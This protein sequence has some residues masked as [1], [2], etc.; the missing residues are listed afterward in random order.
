MQW[1]TQ[2]A[3][4]SWL[5]VLIFVL[6]QFAIT[7]GIPGKMTPTPLGAGKGILELAQTNAL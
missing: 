4:R 1:V 5:L 6:W 7:F 2:I 3:K